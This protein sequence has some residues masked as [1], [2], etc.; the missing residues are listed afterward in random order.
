MKPP[1]VQQSCVVPYRLGDR[2]LEILLITS[3]N[4]GRWIVPKGTVEPNMTPQASAAKEA[5]E[6]AGILGEPGSDSLGEYF[7]S[8][9]DQVYRV[10]IFP[11]RVATELEDWDEKPF[12]R[13]IWVS[14]DEAVSR[15]TETAVMAAIMQLSEYAR[16]DGVSQ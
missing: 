15:V 13:R 7:Y 2:G 1:P 10:V 14:A 16:R 5:L 11:F 9:F 6:E 8:K 3:R 12:R 4:T